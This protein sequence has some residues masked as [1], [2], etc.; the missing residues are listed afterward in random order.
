[1]YSD[2]LTA[3][4]AAGRHGDGDGDVTNRQPAMTYREYL[5]KYYGDSVRRQTPTGDMLDDDNDTSYLSDG[6]VD[7]NM[8]YR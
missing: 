5:Q 2:Y 7:Y 4:A 8:N 6:C 1:M 3:A